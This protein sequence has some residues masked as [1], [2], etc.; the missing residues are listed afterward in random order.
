[1][2]ETKQEIA[3]LKFDTF[4]LHQ[5]FLLPVSS[6]SVSFKRAKASISQAQLDV[7]N[8]IPPSRLG[9]T[10]LRLIR[11]CFYVEI[12]IKGNS[13][14]KHKCVYAVMLPFNSYG[15][16]SK[17]SLQ[18]MKGIHL[19]YWQQNAQFEVLASLANHF[20]GISI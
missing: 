7:L 16:T 9:K 13:D 10:S 12:A 19:P 11:I 2:Q 18:Q 15:D 6:Q 3:K 14:F 4:C 17:R 20:T 1:M 5:S 8:P